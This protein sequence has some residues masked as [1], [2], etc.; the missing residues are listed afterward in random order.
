MCGIGSPLRKR[1]TFPRISLSLFST[2]LGGNANDR[3]PRVHPH[4]R[5][6]LVWMELAARTSCRRC[7]SLFPFLSLFSHPPY[8]G[9]QSPVPLPCS[10]VVEKSSPGGGSLICITLPRRRGSR[11]F[12]MPSDT[13]FL[14]TFPLIFLLPRAPFHPRRTHTE[15]D[16][17]S[18]FSLNMMPETPPP[19]IF[20]FSLFLL[21]SV[22]CCR[23]VDSRFPLKQT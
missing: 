11:F 6:V 3:L 13:S 18:F 21:R 5:F 22:F 1:S 20:S 23:R 17:R 9:T 16:P 19:L 12:A 15:E 7:C 4:R 8:H 10:L 2:D 14:R